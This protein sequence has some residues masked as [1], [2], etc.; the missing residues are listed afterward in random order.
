M[1]VSNTSPI[2]NLAAIGQLRL[3]QALYGSIYSP[4]AVYEEIT[5]FPVEPGAAEVK[6]YEWIIARACLRSDIVV[7]LQ[8]ELDA[9]EAEAIALAL[10]M[11]TLLLIDER[12]G[13]R[14]ASRLGVRKLGLLGVLVKAKRKGHVHE[15]RPL[16]RKLRRDAGFW[17]SDTLY[18]RIV[19]HVD[20]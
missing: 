4:E 19:E 15:V 8:G 14:A 12:A 3:L 20:E 7:A 11:D 5:R 9:G 2:I 13:R 1:V 6:A 10:E 16:L 18:A 17:I